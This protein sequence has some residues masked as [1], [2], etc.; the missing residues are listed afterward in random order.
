MGRLDRLDR[1]SAEQETQL[2]VIRDEWRALGLATA[3]ADRLRAERGMRAAYEAAGLPPPSMFL[4]VRSPLEGVLSTMHL[5]VTS[6]LAEPSASRRWLAAALRAAYL[7]LVGRPGEEPW[8]HPW[9]P[10][11]Q[12]PGDR[13]TPYLAG[14]KLDSRAVRD[15]V[16]RRLPGRIG[17]V[18]Q[19]DVRWHV[20]RHA[21]SPVVAE[22]QSRAWDRLRD[23]VEERY[24]ERWPWVRAWSV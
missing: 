24:A 5:A 23:H 18:V 20:L 3:P 10:L 12:V 2:T 6:A 19:G 4:W 11:R 13:L 14:T 22:I 15:H 17:R 9:A 7:D 8:G 21:W 16:A 1:L